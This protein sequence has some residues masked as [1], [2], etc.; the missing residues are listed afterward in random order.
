MTTLAS[1]EFL[2]HLKTLYPLRNT[3]SGTEA[4]LQNPYYV[5]AAVA[6]SSSNRPEAVPVVFQHV[7]ADLKKAQAEQQ[8]SA[9]EAHKEQLYLARRIREA[10]LKGGLLCGA[11]RVRRICA[12]PLEEC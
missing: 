6:Y 9:E 11:S 10:I 4:V 8:A 2:N 1:A 5:V 7:L 3:L 12:R